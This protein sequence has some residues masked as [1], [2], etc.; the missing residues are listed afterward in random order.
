MRA[1]NPLSVLMHCIKFALSMLGVVPIAVH[2]Q[3]SVG[4]N[5]SSTGAGA[6]Q[7]IPQRELISLLPESIGGLKV[8][9]VFLDNAS[10][11]SAAHRNARKLVEEDRVDVFIAGSTV[12]CTL[13]SSEVSF[14]TKTPQLAL[15][16]V[17]LAR[18]RQM[19]TFSIPQSV[20]L[21]I[22]AVAEHMSANGVKSV[23]YIGYSDAYGDV[24]YKSLAAAAP[25]YA[26]KLLGD[27]RYARTDSSVLPQVL[28]TLAVKPDA[29]LI[30]AGGTPAALP[31]LS[32]VDKGY[33]GKVYHTHGAV[34]A[35]FL[36][37][38]GKSA[39]GS[40][41]PIGPVIAYTELAP[42]DP[43]RK[44]SGEF[45]RLMEKS[46]PGSVSVFASWA[47][48]AYLILAK[49]V[50]VATAK[51]KPGTPEFRLALRDAIENNTKGL[52]GTNGIYEITAF[53][54]TGLDKRARVIVQVTN[55]TWRLAKSK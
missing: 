22:D 27:E 13:A 50:P 28:K 53:D 6:S 40:L 41:A 30:G 42:D 21:M 54:H 23:S 52:V 46:S 1:S 10:D 48:D 38:A 16:P 3:L 36:R 43:I 25:K 55:A 29:V 51:T 5:L 7:G 34:N 17:V 33:K 37:V 20:D 31:Q 2:A 18:D 24:V 8:K 4:V 35:D 9:Y 32:L 14:E 49:A 26:L 44:V 15:S 19:W 11:P 39:E 47:Y 12:P 45:V